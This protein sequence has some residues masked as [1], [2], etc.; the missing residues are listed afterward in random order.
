MTDPDDPTGST[1]APA[2]GEA[3]ARQRTHLPLAPTSAG[4]PPDVELRNG[5]DKY[6]LRDLPDIDCAAHYHLCQA[7]C[8]RF[9]FPLTRQDLVEGVVRWDP[10]HPYRIQQNEGVCVHRNGHACSVYEDRPGICRTYDCR[11]DKRIWID[12][13]RRIPAA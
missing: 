12:Y 1:A 8:C 4:S 11:R 10:E 6:D 9:T 13:E 3:P 2:P 5:P 7:R